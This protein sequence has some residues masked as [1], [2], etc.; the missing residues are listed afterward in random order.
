MKQK[1]DPSKGFLPQTPTNVAL[2]EEV[3][4]EIMKERIPQ[5]HSNVTHFFVD[6]EEKNEHE[7]NL[8]Q[9]ELSMQT[10]INIFLRLLQQIATRTIFRCERVVDYTQLLILTNDSHVKTLHKITKGKKR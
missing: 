10:I 9:K 2:K 3:I 4:V 6:I 1:M 5:S 8:S 7:V